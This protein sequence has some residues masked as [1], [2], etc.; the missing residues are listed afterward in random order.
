MTAQ[1][2]RINYIGDE[3]ADIAD[4]LKGSTNF[5]ASCY[6]V[7]KVQTMSEARVRV[8]AKRSEKSLASAPKL[9]SLPPTTASFY[10]NTMR[11]HFQACVWKHDVD[12][13][14]P[15]L[16]HLNTDEPDV[17]NRKRWCH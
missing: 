13:N 4:V 12:E 7:D 10:R 15:L 8:W 17:M 14:P 2:C 6:S 9:P 5:V 3:T 16:T 1:K 11:A